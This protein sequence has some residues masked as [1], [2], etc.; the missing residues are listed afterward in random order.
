MYVQYEKLYI[1]ESGETSNK[2]QINI[3]YRLLSSIRNFKNILRHIV[4]MHI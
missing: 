4:D 3:F 2:N 1:F